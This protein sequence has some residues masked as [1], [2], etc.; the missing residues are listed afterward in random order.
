MYKEL[1]GKESNRVKNRI[2][3]GAVKKFA[4]AIG[5][6]HLIYV[7]EEYGE[8]SRYKGN[9]A[10][11]TFPIVLDYGII[12]GL[13]LPGIGLIHGEQTF[14][15]ERP[16]MV[17]EE[18]FCF[19]KLT[20]YVEKKGTLGSMGILVLESYGEDRHGKM[21]FSSKETIILTDAARRMMEDEDNG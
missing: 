2:E 17:E 8:K 3:R 19:S 12:E 13:Q 16:L 10:P 4:V 6:P 18:I 14:H 5:D 21:I 7:G 9:I 15:Y 1:I 20:N 11:P